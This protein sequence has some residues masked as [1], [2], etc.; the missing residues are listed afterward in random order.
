MVKLV[1]LTMKSTNVIEGIPM[2]EV[3]S[4]GLSDV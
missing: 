2:C 3:S 1:V 4:F